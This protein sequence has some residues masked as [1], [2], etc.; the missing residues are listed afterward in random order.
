MPLAG[1]S[2]AFGSSGSETISMTA[3]SFAFGIPRSAR[4]FCASVASFFLSRIDTLL[5]PQIQKVADA[6]GPKADIARL[7]PGTIAVANAKVAYKKYEIV[8]ATKRW[9]KL[10]DLGAR[11]QRLLWASTST[12]NPAYPDTKYV[13]DLVGTNTVNTMPPETLS[14]TLDHGRTEVTIDRDLDDSR[15]A[16]ARLAEVGIDLKAATDQLTVEGVAAFAKSFDE[17]LANLTTKRT[18]LKAVAR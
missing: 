6:G 16:L 9:R 4:C 3:S 17:L 2:P 7:L 8:T 13:D 11:P 18:R 15:A 10:A 1:T 5:D 14:A 12:K